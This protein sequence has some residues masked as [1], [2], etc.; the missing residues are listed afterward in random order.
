MIDVRACIFPRWLPPSTRDDCIHPSPAE[1][2]KASII[3][4]LG[5][6]LLTALLGAAPAHAAPA[7]LVNADW[8][9]EHIDDDNLVVLEVRYHPHRYLTVGHIQ[10]AVQVQR[11][12][13]LGDN[14]ANPLMRFPSTDAFQATLRRWGINDDSTLVLYDDSRTA[15]ASRV[16]FLLALYGFPMDQV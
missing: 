11:F 10:G 4:S 1:P 13:D 8:L 15:L 6:L 2:M 3:Q 5:F 9:T 16:Y 14:T 12:K 7:Y